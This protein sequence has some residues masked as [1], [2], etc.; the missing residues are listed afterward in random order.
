VGARAARALSRVWTRAAAARVGLKPPGAPTDPE[1][2]EACVSEAGGQDGS[3]LP[4]EAY[5]QAARSLSAEAFAR[6]HGDAFLVLTASRLSRPQGPASTRV[7]LFDERDRGASTAGVSVVVYRA[8]RGDG[9][10]THLVTL[11]RARNNDIAVPDL[12]V[13]RFHAFLKRDAAGGYQIQDA[14]STNG[15]TVNGASVPARGAGPAVPLKAGDS[16][17]LGQVDF[18]FL[19][20]EALRRF[21]LQYE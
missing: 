19:D 6:Q 3:E 2:Q 9:S 12:S 11:G 17:R 8:R 16:V 4:I 21:A 13:S 20:A 10:V 14:G 15:T 1:G 7:E 5:A 18:T